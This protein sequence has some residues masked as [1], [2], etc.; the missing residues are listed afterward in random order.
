MSR[1]FYCLKT[2][3][4]HSLQSE[5]ELERFAEFL[6]NQKIRT[7]PKLK[8]ITRAQKSAKHLIYMLIYFDYN[9]DKN[10]YYVGTDA[11][12]PIESGSILIA[13]Q[14][15]PLSFSD[16]STSSIIS[17]GMQ[18]IVV[19]SNVSA[20]VLNQTVTGVL[21]VTYVPGQSQYESATITI[22]T[23][24]GPVTEF[25]GTPFLTSDMVSKMNTTAQQTSSQGGFN[26]LSTNS[27]MPST[28]TYTT[29]A[30]QT[31]TIPSGWH[32][33]G[34]NIG[35]TLDGSSMG[36]N[37]IVIAGSDYFN[38]ASLTTGS[39][40][41]QVWGTKEAENYLTSEYQYGQGTQVANVI[42]GVGNPNNYGLIV[43]GSSVDPEPSSGPDFISEWSWVLDYVPYVGTALDALAQNLTMSSITEPASSEY[44]VQLN[45]NFPN[46]D[47]VLSGSTQENEP[48]G[49]Y[50]YAQQVAF[51]GNVGDEIELVAYIRYETF[52][53]DPYNNTSFVYFNNT[54]DCYMYPTVQEQEG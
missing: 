22:N 47:Y 19:S 21:G 41:I 33:Q 51:S 43:Y 52:T 18:V 3:I 1:A 23:P 46:V 45:H 38:S 15:I 9:Y 48:E 40:R 26:T 2:G 24:T 36:F 12:H 11:T 16:E 31:G 6:V 4:G 10:F 50:S 5:R 27:G 49:N 44:Y 34:R 8:V 42:M 35:N 28:Q 25:F 14:A 53:Y 20:T 13:N 30:P 29:V 17:D 32:Y 7:I 54:G 37:T 39:E